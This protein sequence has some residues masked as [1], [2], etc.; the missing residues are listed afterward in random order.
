MDKKKYLMM[1]EQLGNEP[2]EEEI[3]ADFS[4]FPYI[5]QIAIS[6]FA[7][8]PDI[9]EG[10]SGTY[11]GKDYTLLPYL[12]GIY[13]IENHA[14]LMQFINMIGSIVMQQRTEEQKQRQRK[15]KNKKV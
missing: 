10:F 6:I 13:E 8:L 3:P 5:I 4:D 15:S 7:M 9:W 2:K 1:C 14:Q 11:M 12:A